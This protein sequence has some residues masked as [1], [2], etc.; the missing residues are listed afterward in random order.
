[1]KPTPPK[2]QAPAPN[3]SVPAAPVESEAPKQAPSPPVDKPADTE[4]EAAQVQVGMAKAVR[5]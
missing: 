1:V 3:G 2:R 5:K 4:S